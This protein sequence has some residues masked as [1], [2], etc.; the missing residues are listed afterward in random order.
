[1]CHFPAM[2]LLFD[3]GPAKPL[4]THVAMPL[5]NRAIL[6][7]LVGWGEQTHCLCLTASKL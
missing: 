6:G 5:G 1:M 7:P 2:N 4:W 3:L